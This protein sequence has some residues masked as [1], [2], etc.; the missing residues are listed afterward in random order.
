V[1]PPYHTLIYV[2]RATA[3]L[4]V[5]EIEAIGEVAQRRNTACGV[6]GAL[7]F[8]A[9]HFLQ[10]LEGPASEVH[11]TFARIERDQRHRDVR[12][13]IGGETQE[14]L[15]A[16]WSMRRVA[17]PSGDDRTVTAFLAALHRNPG[18]TVHAHTALRLLSRL[19]AEQPASAGAT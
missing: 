10:A 5:A 17:P 15:F 6:S 11:A 3:G 14:R 13:L 7:L 8:Y 4:S 9:G 18:D 2:S 16:Q 12:V 1:P 19:A